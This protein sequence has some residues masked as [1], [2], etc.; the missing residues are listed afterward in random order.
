MGV[1]TQGFGHKN[2]EARLFWMVSWAL[3]R[4][5]KKKPNE[6]G[7]LTSKNKKRK[8]YLRID[9]KKKYSFCLGVKCSF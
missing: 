8:K 2:S 7:D 5:K 4:E 6:N 9:E 1:C 3:Y